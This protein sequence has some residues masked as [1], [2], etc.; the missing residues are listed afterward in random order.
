MSFPSLEE[1]NTIPQ[2]R[3]SISQY[4]PRGIRIGEEGRIT[5]RVFKAA[6]GA[7]GVG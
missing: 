3:P 2:A 1:T 6:G 4:N 7:F 5:I